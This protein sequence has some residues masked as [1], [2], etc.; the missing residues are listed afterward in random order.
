[1]PGRFKFFY[2]KGCAFYESESR[3]LLNFRVCFFC[4]FYLKRIDMLQP[5]EHINLIFTKLSFSRA[6]MFSLLA[7][8]F[9]LVNL[10]QLFLSR[11][12]DISREIYKL[13]AYY[14][15]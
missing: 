3:C 1:M 15:H 10:M 14:A 5:K 2:E 9:S 11:S 4:S 8:V 6:Y 13:F 7:I 12:D